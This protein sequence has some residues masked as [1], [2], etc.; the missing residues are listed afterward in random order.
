MTAKDQ[1]KLEV[2]TPE[3]E[4]FCGMVEDFYFPALVGETGV[5]RNHAPML[6]IVVPGVVR[7][8]QNGALRKMAVGRG[9]LDLRQN[10]AKLLVASAELT[11]DIDA[12]RAE[13]ARERA[14]KRLREQAKTLDRAR[15]EAALARAVARLKAL[16]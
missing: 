5:L 14:E 15:A 11:E 12:A 7:F 6:S 9:F 10:E 1:I 16:E 3:K 2:V 8:R 4:V 13:A